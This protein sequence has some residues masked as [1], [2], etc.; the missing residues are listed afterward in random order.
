EPIGEGFEMLSNRR[1]LKR[2]LDSHRIELDVINYEKP[3][4]F[5][6]LE[7]RLRSRTQERK[8]GAEPGEALALKFV[9]PESGFFKFRLHIRDE[10][11]IRQFLNVLKVE[12]G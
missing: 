3:C 7:Q 6:K 12:P 11:F 10:F 1:I 8:H 9:M 5:R 4:L 2:F